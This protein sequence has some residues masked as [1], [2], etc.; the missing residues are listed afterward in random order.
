VSTTPLAN[1]PLALLIL[2]ANVLMIRRFTTGNADAG[3][4]F[5]TG[6]NDSGSKFA[7][8][9]STTLVLKSLGCPEPEFV[10]D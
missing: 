5:A 8:T 2:V 6:V 9:G 7:T 10:N 4:K 1:L 3:G